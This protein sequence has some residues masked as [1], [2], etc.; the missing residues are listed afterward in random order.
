MSFYSSASPCLLPVRSLTSVLKSSK[1]IGHLLQK[2]SRNPSVSSCVPNLQAGH[3]LVEE[4]VQACETDLRHK[5]IT[6]YHQHSRHGLGYIKSSKIP[7]DKS[8]RDYRTFI[9]KHYKEIDHAYGISKAVQLKVQG[10]W[11]RW[12]NY[13][14]QNFSWKS[15]L[16]MPVNLSSFCLSST[17]DTLPSPSNLKRWKLTAEASCFPCNKD[18][19]TT[20]HIL[21]AC[22]VA[23]SQGR[24][25]LRHDNVLRIIITNIISSIKNIKSTVPASKQ[26]IKI[27]FVKGTRVKNKNSS[28]SGILHQ[29]GS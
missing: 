10:Q 16:A 27:K 17:Y 14:Q 4:A 26:P 6:G 22:K 20:S 9:S 3:W 25:T 28:L 23:L 12:L 15:L 5:S 13:I 19:C 11:T 8:S 2:H 29:A 18:T 1:I 21:G 24:F 7:P